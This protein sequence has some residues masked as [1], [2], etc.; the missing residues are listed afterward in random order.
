MR[1]LE[2][3]YEVVGVC[4]GLLVA[5]LTKQKELGGAC[6]DI[7]V[8]PSCNQKSCRLQGL[9]HQ[10]QLHLTMNRQ[11]QKLANGLILVRT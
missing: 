1:H 5:P 9:G 8:I 10:K 7:F 6:P 4:Q 3:V 11:F 2:E